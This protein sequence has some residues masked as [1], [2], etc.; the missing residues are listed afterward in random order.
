MNVKIPLFSSFVT[1]IITLDTKNPESETKITP[2]DKGASIF[3]AHILL[4]GLCRVLASTNTHYY[5]LPTP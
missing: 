3:N 2:F 5:F 4:C 1:A